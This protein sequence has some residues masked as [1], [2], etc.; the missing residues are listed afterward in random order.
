MRVGLKL[1]LLA[2]SALLLASQAHAGPSNVPPPAGALLDLAGNP[3]PADNAYNH[4]SVSFVAANTSTAISFALRNDP[5]F[6]YLDDIS[7][8]DQTTS[9]GNLIVNGGFESGAVGAAAPVGWS[10]INPFAATFSGA[11]GAL[12]DRTGTG[13]N[14]YEDGSVQA[15]D[16]ISQQIATIIGDT[17][18]IDFYVGTNTTGD[19]FRALSTNDNVIDDGG[20]AI[21]VL[22]YADLTPPTLATDAPEPASL[23]L[24]GVGLAGVGAL[25]RR[26]KPA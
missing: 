18:Q 3:L 15:Y 26:R 16:A 2:T 7:V 10:Y 13:S 23:A 21:D 19:V 20:N 4:Y 8:S 9:G 25:R 6:L 1:A 12:R 17:Y 5:G 22:V 11:V 24:L 14:S